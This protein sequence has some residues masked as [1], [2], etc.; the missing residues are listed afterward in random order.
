[1]PIKDIVHIYKCRFC[2]K[3]FTMFDGANGELIFFPENVM[4]P[5]HGEL[6]LVYHLRN[7][8]KHEYDMDRTFYGDNKHLINTNYILMNGEEK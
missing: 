6:E 8:H 3:K 1:M 2:G 4:W 7:C 5:T